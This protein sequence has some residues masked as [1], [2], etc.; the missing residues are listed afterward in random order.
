MKTAVVVMILL[1]AIS[2]AALAHGGHDHV[3]GTVTKVT[4]DT[5]Q[6]KTTNGETKDVTIDDKTT[7]TMAGKK[8]SASDVKEGARVVIDVHAMKGMPNMLQAQS[9]KIGAAPKP[10]SSTSPKKAT[11]QK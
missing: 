11:K 1:L 2:T 7:Y 3:M 10:S 9:V 5:I 8:A 4:A 6:V